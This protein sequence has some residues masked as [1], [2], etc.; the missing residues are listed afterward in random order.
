MSE[1]VFPCDYIIKA[2]FGSEMAVA[3]FMAE[4]V[5]LIQKCPRTSEV[6]GHSPK[7]HHL[8]G[9]IQTHSSLIPITFVHTGRGSW[10]L[11]RAA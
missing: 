7:N 5:P 6:L 9:L 4:I 1:S 10:K 8:T 11:R 3:G 2:M